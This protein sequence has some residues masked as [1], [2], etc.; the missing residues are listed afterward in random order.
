MVWAGAVGP[1]EELSGIPVL[2]V[3]DQAHA[4]CVRDSSLNVLTAQWR[5][6]GVSP[7]GLDV[8]VSVKVCVPSAKR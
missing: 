4:A 7:E 8:Q 1:T 3:I 5:C 2:N 6:D